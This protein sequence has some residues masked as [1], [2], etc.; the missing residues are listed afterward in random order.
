MSKHGVC[1]VHMQG[2]QLCPEVMEALSKFL[3][4]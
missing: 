4:S 1:A 3:M 2:M